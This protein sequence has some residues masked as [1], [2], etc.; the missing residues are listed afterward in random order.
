MFDHAVNVYGR[1]PVTGFARRAI[2]NTGVQYGLA[3]LNAGAITT[4]QFLDL[5]EK[6]G[7]HDKDGNLVPSRAVADLAA[8]RAAYQTGRITY[9]GNGLAR[10]PIIDFRAYSDR[11]ERGDVHLKYH[12]FSFRERLKAA[13][14]AAAN[15]VILLAGAQT[16]ASYAVQAYAIAKMDEWLTNLARDAS[17]DPTI[18]KIV[19]AK[20]ADLVDSCYT[21]TGERIVE[22][23]TFSGGECNKL[24]PTFPPP[25]MIAGGPVTNNILKCQFKPVDF[26]DYKVTFTKAEKDQ[27]RSIFPNGVCDWKKPGFE[28]Q[29]PLGTW[30]RY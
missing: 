2:D 13:N 14:G 22:T 7:G 21:S 29:K 28:Q 20:P 8:V 23:Q 11:T 16:P 9:G 5:N 10:L 18:D 24:Y 15:E 30:L 17:S 1:D 26:E 19:R 3:A 25:R 27:L 6:I 4:A 12:S